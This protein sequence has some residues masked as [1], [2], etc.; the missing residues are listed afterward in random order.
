MIR[1][2][3][4]EDDF[5]NSHVLKRVMPDPDGSNACDEVLEQYFH[6]ARKEQRI[7]LAGFDEKLNRR[8]EVVQ[9][10]KLE[11]EHEAD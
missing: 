6:H 1:N 8:Q 11:Q 5:W 7:P 2:L 3:I 10:M 9:L 4:S